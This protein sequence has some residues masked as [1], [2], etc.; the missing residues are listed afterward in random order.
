MKQHKILFTS[1]GRRVE[2]IQ[3]FRIA[4]NKLDI[5][6]QIWGADI[7]DTAPAL[8]FCDRTFKASRICNPNYI[9]ELIELCKKNDI[10]VLIPTIDTDL[11]LFA[12]HK[13]DFAK[14]GTRVM[15]SEE[16]KIKICRDKRLTAKYFSSVGLLSPQPVDN[17]KLYDNGFPAFIKPKD[18]SSSIMAYKV[19]NKEELE[20]YASQIPDYIVQPFIDGEEYTVDIFCDF[21]G[22]PIYIT[23][24]IRLA[25]RAGEVL[26]TKV[27]REESIINEMKRFLAEYRPCGAITVQ[28]IKQKDT[29]KNYY[30]E[31]NPRFGGGAPLSMK[32]GANSAEALLRLLDG[33]K[34]VYAENS[35][36]ESVFSRY[37]QSVCTDHELGWIKAVVFDLDDTLYYERDYV[38]S[39]FKAVANVLTEVDNCYDKLWNAFISGKTAIDYVL[40]LEGIYSEELKAKCLDVYR[41]HEPNISLS[42]EVKYT[43]EKLRES[44]LKIGII[45][46]GRP[47]GQRNKIRALGLENYVDEI[48]VTDE[49]GGIKFRKPNDISFRIMQLKLNVPFPQMLY[50]GD[51]V[52]KDFI[53]PKQLG[54]QTLLF[55][56]EHG[57]YNKHEK[58]A[59][60]R[61]KNVQNIS[62]LLKILN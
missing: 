31:I 11:L 47:I 49:I 48:I 21:D 14:I 41:K 34:I 4:A 28:L 7:T 27:V 56:S 33:E 51:N 1:V 9:P 20:V 37:D 3:A 10:D 23:P 39:G 58:D 12:E 15:V 22:N 13:E 60:F 42:N 45:T 5:K 57:L 46:D 52:A 38:K 19:E 2:L 61:D 17:Y 16:E 36:F 43:L 26:K 30:I 18:G 44:G 6:L 50:V 62:D 25:V 55:E 8:L 35:I 32:S 54:M 59:F 29:G 40:E 24:R 53:A